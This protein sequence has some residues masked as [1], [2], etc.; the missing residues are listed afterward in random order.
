ML[1]SS[2]PKP[3]PEISWV[4]S[5]PETDGQYLCGF[6]VRPGD[7]SLFKRIMVAVCRRESV[8]RDTYSLEGDV[9]LDG[10]LRMTDLKF[11]P[12]KER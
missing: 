1:G 9:I 12:K 5:D 7:G 6:A 8:D 10:M 2:M 11:I 3:T 4:L